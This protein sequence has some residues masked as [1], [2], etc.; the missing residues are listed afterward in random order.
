[1]SKQLFRV[2]TK[3]L[4][5]Y[6]YTQTFHRSATAVD[7]SSQLIYTLQMKVLV[8]TPEWYCIS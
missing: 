6:V 1:M 5:I 8:S 4:H 3:D 2:Q 7:W